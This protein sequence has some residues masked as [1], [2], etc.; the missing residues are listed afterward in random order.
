MKRLISSK[1]YQDRQIRCLSCSKFIGFQKLDAQIL[2]L[3]NGLTVFNYFSFQCECGKNASWQAPLL[4]NES[5]TV[6]NLYPD[7]EELRS[8]A[9]KLASRG[10]TKIHNKFRARANLK[11]KTKYLGLFDTEMEARQAVLSAKTIRANR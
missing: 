7:T 2:I 6:D 3:A 8:R 1:I 4:P 9:K 11:G 5:P 10:V